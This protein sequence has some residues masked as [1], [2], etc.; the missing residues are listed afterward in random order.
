MAKHSST[1]R[2]FTLVELLVVIGI[3]ALLIS[4]LLPALSKAREQANKTACL[5]NLKQ[6]GFAMIAYCTDNKGNFPRPATGTS[7]GEDWLFWQSGRNLDDSRIVAYLGGTF[8]PRLF[9]CP[10][11]TEIS[12][13]KNGF[14]YSYTVNETMCLAAQAIAGSGGHGAH[15]GIPA[16]DSS[17]DPVSPPTIKLVQVIHA[18]DKIMIIDESA[19]TIDDGCWA[20]ENF[21]TASTSN[22]L[23]ARHNKGTE[24]A[25]DIT[26]GRGNAVFADGHA[27]FIDRSYAMNAL[28]WDATWDGI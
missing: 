8:T 14:I 1:R 24:N 15:A 2:G 22:V 9:Q 3:I 20:P 16:G 27:D 6:L 5:A 19:T 11:D 21:S 10:S 17:T 18:S 13:H 28:Y 25:A 7:L 4:I 23:S 12:A 26:S